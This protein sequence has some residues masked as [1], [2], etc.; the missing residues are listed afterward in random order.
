MIALL[1]DHPDAITLYKIGPWWCQMH[2]IMQASSILMLELVH[3]SC[4]MPK[5]ANHIIRTMK[6]VF[7]WLHNMAEE[8][9]AAKRAWKVAVDLLQKV[10]PMVN[11]D[12]SDVNLNGPSS[13]PAPVG[14]PEPPPNVPQNYSQP[15]ALSSGPSAFPQMQHARPTQSSQNLGG[16][17]SGP[18]IDVSHYSTMTLL[19]RQ[20]CA[21]PTSQV[22]EVVPF[23]QPENVS[24]PL[25]PQQLFDPKLFFGESLIDHHY[26]GFPQTNDDPFGVPIYTSY[27]QFEPFNQTAVEPQIN[28]RF[29]GDEW[30]N[31]AGMDVDGE[32]GAQGLAL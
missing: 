30:F 31:S 11:A 1:P 32:E 10:A 8:S 20:N 5:E 16:Y 7:S 15:L 4:H 2:L 26:Y 3:Q 6:K 25:Q 24:I 22:P 18:G 19:Q 13:R 12:V 28:S 29:F 27:D 17:S 9:G 23:Q 21:A 14:V